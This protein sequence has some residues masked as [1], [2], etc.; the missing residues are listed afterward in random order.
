MPIESYPNQKIVQIHRN[1][2]KQTKDSKKPFVVAYTDVIGKASTNLG[3]K[4]TAFKLYMY[5]LCNQDN[6]RFALSPQAFANEFGVSLKSAKDAVNDLIEAGYL[7]LREKKTYDFYETP[8]FDELEPE[9]EIR[10][11]FKT[12]SGKTLELTFTELVDYVG[13]KEKAEE[14]WRT[15]Q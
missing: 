8:H 2:P 11:T 12:K 13:S 6:Y 3:T 7:V 10:K 14:K 5:L 15:A 9:N 1:M 4:H